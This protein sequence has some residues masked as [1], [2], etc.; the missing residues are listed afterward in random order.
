VPVIVQNSQ[1]VKYRLFRENEAKGFDLKRR[2]NA[3]SVYV[4]QPQDLVGRNPVTLLFCVGL[5]LIFSFASNPLSR[6]PRGGNRNNSGRRADCTH[7]LRSPLILPCSL[8]L[9]RFIAFGLSTG[10]GSIFLAK[11]PQK[12][13]HLD[14][15]STL[16][17]NNTLL[18]S[19]SHTN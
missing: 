19:R 12:N 4:N 6:S 13:L 8:F 16:I 3:A 5:I 1:M 7:L 2:K 15:P 10:Q 18:F 9:F 17:E 11:R 14:L